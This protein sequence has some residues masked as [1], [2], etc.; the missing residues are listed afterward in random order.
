LKPFSFD[1]DLADDSDRIFFAE[2][3]V[4]ALRYATRDFAG[5]EKLRA[6]RLALR[7]LAGLLD[8]P[9]VQ[10]DYL[11]SLECE[12]RSLLEVNAHP[13][14]LERARP[15]PIDLPWLV[16]QL[17]ELADLR[18]HAEEVFEQHDHGVVY[19]VRLAPEDLGALLWHPAMGIEAT[20]PIPAT[21][22][23]AKVIVP[24][25]FVAVPARCG[26][27]EISRYGR[28]LLAAL[29]ERG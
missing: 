2:T 4:R 16:Q 14:A 23:V 6:L 28:G 15:R 18:R 9:R 7:D 21:R 11:R 12:Q 17:A 22:L 27:Y 19:A 13:A 20:A 8:D 26:A 24:A 1:H 29:R 3:A 5:G 25:T 10:G